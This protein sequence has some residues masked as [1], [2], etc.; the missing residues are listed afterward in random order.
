MRILFVEPNAEPRAIEIDGSLASMQAPVGGLIEAVYPF[1]DPVALICNDEGKLTGLPQNRPLKHPET[2]EIYDTVCG[3]FFLCSAPSDSENFESLSE[4]L[5]ENIP[6]SLPCRSSSA[7]TAARNTAKTSYFRLTV[8]FF[9]RTVWK[10][11]PFSALTAVSASGGTTTPE[12]NP[13]RSVRTAMT[14][15]TQTVTAAVISSASA[16]PITPARAMATNIRSAMTA[17]RAALP[18]SRSRTTITSL[19]RCSAETATA[20]SA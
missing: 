15:T 20:S 19:S 17:T 8:S 16:R 10:P 3:P 2:G 1:E 14:V 18:A 13:R 4:E 6:S 9:V 12:M 5:I 7:R 11:K